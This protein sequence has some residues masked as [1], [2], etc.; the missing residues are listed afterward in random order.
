MLALLRCSASGAFAVLTLSTRQL[1]LTPYK[2]PNK[3]SYLGGASRSLYNI[4]NALARI[5][6]SSRALLTVGLAARLAAGLA[7][8][9]LV[10]GVGAI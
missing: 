4:D 2:I 1:H 7:I 9:G 6:R 8:G 5:K 10:E 3:A